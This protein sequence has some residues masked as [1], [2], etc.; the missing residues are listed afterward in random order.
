MTGSEPLLAVRDLRIAFR[1]AAGLVRAVNGVSFTV[2]KGSV[3]GLVGESGCG[4]SVTA[5]ALMGL[6]RTSRDAQCAGE[7]LFR[8]R[9]LLTVPE[10]ELR[11]VR[12]KEIAMIFQD[13]MTC[14]NPVR[15]VGAQIA[16]T[17]KLHTDLSKAEMR[18]RCIDL[19]GEVGIP[20]PAARLDDY[21]HQFSGGMRQRV[22]IAMALAC[23]PSV[24]IADEPTTALDVTIQAQIIDLL[25]RLRHRHG[26]AIILIT[27]D[28]GVVADVAD[29]ILVMYAGR[30]VEQGPK[31]ELFADPLH[32]YTWGLLSSI[33]R[34]DRE[35]P[36]R[37]P[38][39]EGAPPS[40]IDIPPGCAF[41]P[42]CRHAFE[43]CGEEPPLEGRIGGSVHL[44][45]CWLTNQEKRRLQPARRTL[46]TA[47]RV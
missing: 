45:R 23:D 29:E 7:V 40:L 36:R 46:E 24:L 12:G 14:L 39:I 20:N 43:T 41:R 42:R 27:H 33:P 16:E 3:V 35:R 6:N 2:E 44:D 18:S 37:L 11:E 21:P 5:H 19:L 30:L 15:R 38:S 32:P 17:L 34:V 8:G 26:S 25:E 28:L 9:N 1:T 10:R 22:M 13:P 4:K 47:T 31:R